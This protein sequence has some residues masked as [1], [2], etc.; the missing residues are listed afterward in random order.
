M[1]FRESAYFY[2]LMEN[3]CKKCVTMSEDTGYRV[4]NE[5]YKFPEKVR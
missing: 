1:R 2:M 5:Q 3:K 4:C